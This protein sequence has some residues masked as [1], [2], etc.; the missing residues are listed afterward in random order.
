LVGMPGIAGIPD[1]GQDGVD[2][3]LGNLVGAEPG[4]AVAGRGLHPIVRG[5]AMVVADDDHVTSAHLALGS[6]WN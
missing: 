5:E 1:A 3:A 4:V 6:H 2:E